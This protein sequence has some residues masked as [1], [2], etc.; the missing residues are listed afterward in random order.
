MPIEARRQPTSPTSSPTASRPHLL[1][2]E[3]DPFTGLSALRARYAAGL[4]PGSDVCGNAVTWLITGDAASAD[5]AVAQLRESGPARV[6]AGAYPAIV[7]RALAFDWLSAYPG[8]DIALKDRVATEL[9]DA[10]ERMLQD[11]SLT[12]PAAVSYQNYPVRYLALASFAVAAAARHPLTADR[13][14]P[15]NDRLRRSFDNVLETAEFL[16]PDGGFHESMDYMRITMAAMVLMAELRRT[17]DGPDPAWKYGVFRNISQTYLYKVL[18]DGSSSR[19]GDDEYPLREANDNLVLAY[20]VS[21]FKDPYAAWMLRDSGWSK[22]SPR[23]TTVEF[24]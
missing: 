23:L 21:R 11:V 19:E 16:T 3:T 24:L 8:F 10:A 7:C 22:S 13:V 2:S 15:L 14:A 1:L 12:D 20:A 5:R 18:A 6:N 17:T 9:A 4:R